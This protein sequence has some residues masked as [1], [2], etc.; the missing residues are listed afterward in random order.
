MKKKWILLFCF[1]IGLSQMLYSDLQPEVEYLLLQNPSYQKW[2]AK[3]VSDYLLQGKYVSF[4]RQYDFETRVKAGKV[5]SYAR[6]EEMAPLEEAITV[7][8]FFLLALQPP[9]SGY[10]IEVRG[11]DKEFG[12]PNWVSTGSEY[13]TDTGYFIEVFKFTPNPE[14]KKSVKKISSLSLR[15]A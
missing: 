12:F 4:G 13:V 9:R 3:N 8:T 11:Y 7:E 14:D 1:G 2:K 6:D 15:G 10:V 5:I